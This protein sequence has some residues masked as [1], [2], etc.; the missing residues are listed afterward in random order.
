V[1][2]HTPPPCVVSSSHGECKGE[3]T[4]VICLDMYRIDSG[5]VS[6]NRFYTLLLMPIFPLHVVYIGTCRN[7][8][9]SKTF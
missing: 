4:I 3:L 2:R 6:V 5:P 8:A 9:G 7:G 1:S